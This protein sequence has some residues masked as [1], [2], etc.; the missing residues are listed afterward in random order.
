MTNTVQSTE[1]DDRWP[2]CS[3]QAPSFPVPLYPASAP[4]QEFYSLTIKE[5]VLILDS[6][7]AWAETLQHNSCNLLFLFLSANP[8]FLRECFSACKCCTS[9]L[10]PELF[11]S[12]SYW[13]IAVTITLPPP[14]S[15]CISIC[16]RDFLWRR[17]ME[18]PSLCLC[19]RLFKGST[20]RDPHVLLM[21]SVLWGN[22][23]YSSAD[24][25]SRS[26]LEQWGVVF[27]PL[28]RSCVFWTSDCFVWQDLRHSRHCTVFKKKKQTFLLW[29]HHP[30][31][32]KAFE[33]TFFHTLLQSLR[34][35]NTHIF[36]R[37]VNL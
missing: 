10:I 18:L 8:L 9:V 15:Y 1:Y 14:D 24:K 30:V 25:S 22:Q 11:E 31:T 34:H 16:S 5:K 23:S 29:K 33:V 28:T 37:L 26:L 17:Q 20:T 36:A 3:S 13:H 19:S 21:R 6:I 12:R 35:E 27:V 7:H 4:Q 2:L 32:P